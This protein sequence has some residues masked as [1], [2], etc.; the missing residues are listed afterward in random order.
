M[1]KWC[2]LKDMKS[3]IGIA[4]ESLACMKAHSSNPI[5]Q[6]GTVSYKIKSV[7]K[8]F[9]RQIYMLHMQGKKDMLGIWHHISRLLL[10]W[11]CVEIVFSKLWLWCFLYWNTESTGVL[12]SP[13]YKQCHIISLKMRRTSIVSSPTTYYD[14]CVWAHDELSSFLSFD[15]TRQPRSKWRT[16]GWGHRSKVLSRFVSVKG[17]IIYRKGKS[18][19][20]W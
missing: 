17:T 16:W 14:V 12:F 2:L 11:F 7:M 9:H 15:V 1:R 3:E 5:Q 18:L 19:R 6:K 10:F 8:G 4:W 20:L 13:I